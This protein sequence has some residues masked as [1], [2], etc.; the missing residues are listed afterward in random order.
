MF[1]NRGLRVLSSRISILFIISFCTIFS[2]EAKPKQQHVFLDTNGTPIPNDILL[3]L[4]TSNIKV[5]NNK[6]TKISD[7]KNNKKTKK[8][9]TSELEQELL[10]A[11]LTGKT[12][13]ATRLVAAG[14]KVNYKNLKGETPLIVAVD[15]GWASMVVS[16]IEHGG[17]L[18]KKNSHG[19]SLLHHSSAKGFVDMSKLLINYGLRPS[20]TTKKKW[21]SLHIAARYGHWQL[22]Q[23]YLQ[24]GVDP[25]K[26][27]S[28]GKTA[29]EIAQIVKHNGIIKILSQVTTARPIG[30]SA[31][32]NRRINRAYYD[33]IENKK[34]KHL[35]EKRM[36][37]KERKN[38]TL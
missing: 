3:S 4:T 28:D 6:N 32:Y 20:E 2:V 30:L 22:V 7:S 11:L 29:L 12:E 36:K 34:K 18:H 13:R 35:W 14:V 26:R 17:K 16:L 5:K 33:A 1:N 37:L 25:N 38:K 10:E 9:S 21:N 23:M 19:L 27:T 8:K 24:L 15:R 31:N